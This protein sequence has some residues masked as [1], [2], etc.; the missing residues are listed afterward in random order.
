M[1]SPG[2]KVPN[3]LQEK[4]REIAPERMKRWKKTKNNTQLWMW[5]VLEIKSNSVKSNIGAWNVKSM[6]QGKLE[7]VKK[8]WTSTFDESA[9]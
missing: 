5:L 9:N 8:K 4:S 1:N 3:M 2:W 7:V 6:N